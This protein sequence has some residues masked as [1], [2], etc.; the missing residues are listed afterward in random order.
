MSLVSLLDDHDYRL[1]SMMAGRERGD[2]LEVVVKFADGPD[3]V[4]AS[5]LCSLNVL[6]RVEA[7]TR[8]LGRSMQS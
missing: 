8:H 6:S 4:N 1:Q 5:L 2:M 7:V 3:R